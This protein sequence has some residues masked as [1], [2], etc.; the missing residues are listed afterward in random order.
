MLN[1]FYPNQER[2]SCFREKSIQ[3]ITLELNI[4]PK[5][6]T[7]L[8]KKK[9]KRLNIEDGRKILR[10]RKFFFFFILFSLIEQRLCQNYRLC[11]ILALKKKE[12]KTFNTH[13]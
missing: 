8:Q 12:S 13:H 10:G 6:Y 11:R 2:R 3:T 5:I 9:K 7:Y 1:F 4:D